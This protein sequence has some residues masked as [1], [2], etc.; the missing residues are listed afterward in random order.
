MRLYPIVTVSGHITVRHIIA[1]RLLSVTCHA[2]E[3][4]SPVQGRGCPTVTRRTVIGPL[5]A[6]VGKNPQRIPI[7]R[8]KWGPTF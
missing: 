8:G 3:Q 5:T 1:C 7:L 6:T 2:R 4:P